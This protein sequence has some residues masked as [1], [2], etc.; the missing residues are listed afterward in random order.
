MLV[1]MIAKSEFI[2]LFTERAM[3]VIVAQQSTPVP[4][5]FDTAESRWAA[6]LA[7]NPEA[8]GEFYYAVRTTGVYCRP[9][10]SAR[11]AQREN[12]AFYG[13]PRDAESAGFRPCKRCRPN[14]SVAD[15]HAVAVQDVCRFLE[16]A[17]VMPK[18]SDLAT[19]A[20][21]SQFHFHRLFR[22]RT[23]VTP[24]AFFEAH[25]A[26]RLR[27]QLTQSSTVTEAVYAAGFSSSSRFYERSNAILGMRPKAFQDGGHGARIRFAVGQCSLGSVLVAATEKGICAISLG[28]DPEKLIRDLQDR[29]PNATLVGADQEFERWI[30]TVIALV[31]NPRACP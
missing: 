13:T 2:T 18:L 31:E 16:N 10:C 4:P 19:T 22:S 21:L 7:R 8:D 27:A 15:T 12:V 25:R 5:R 23:G 30:A 1:S 9:S 6:V 17:D 29:F 26:N 14:E 28:D 11:R 20:G 3:P 24:K